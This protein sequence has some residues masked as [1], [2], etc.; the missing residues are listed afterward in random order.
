MKSAR[1]PLLIVLVTADLLRHPKDFGFPLS[2]TSRTGTRIQ[3]DKGAT[4]F[5]DVPLNPLRHPEKMATGGFLEE[6]ISVVIDEELSDFESIKEKQVKVRI[7]IATV[8]HR[9]THPGASIAISLTSTTRITKLHYRLCLHSD[10][11]R[12]PT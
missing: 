8:A 2:E 4:P 7:S 6:N 10:F 11:Q 3:E 9:G 1:C 12:P 5:A